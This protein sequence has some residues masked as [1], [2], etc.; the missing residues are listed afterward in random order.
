MRWGASFFYWLCENLLDLNLPRNSTEFQ[1]LSRR[2]VNAISQIRD[3]YR[4]LRLLSDYV[5]YENQSFIYEPISR[6]GKP[7]SRGFL[8]AVNLAIGIVVTNS[9]HPLRFVSWL[10]LFASVLNGL[11]IVYV[12]SINIFEFE[13]SKGWTT[14]SLQNAMMFC[15]TFAVLTVLSEYIGRILDESKE[16][17]LYYVLEEKTSSVLLTASEQRNVVRESL[18]VGHDARD[19]VPG[20]VRQPVKAEGK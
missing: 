15:L 16:R 18:Q 20:E 6:Y 1:V 17:P 3:K 5:G 2:A 9:T 8:E 4:Y 10:S 13:V 12:A 14:L 11:Y 7:R 19:G